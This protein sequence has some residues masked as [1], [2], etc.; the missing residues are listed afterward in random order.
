[1]VKKID[2]FEK[3]VLGH[4]NPGGHEV[5]DTLDTR[6]HKL[7]GHLL[8]PGRR[9]GD[10]AYARVELFRAF[11][12][13]VDVLDGDARDFIADFFRVGIKG[14][15]VVFAALEKVTVVELRAAEF[16]RAHEY[17]IPRPVRAQGLGNRS[18]E[19]GYVVTDAAYAEFSE[20]C[21]IFTNL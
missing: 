15:D 4:E 10:D 20:I 9:R 5:E 13:A 3:D 1:M 8:G 2:V 14:A 7:V 12:E 17:A 6:F 21:E 19:V 18:H 11:L 16:P